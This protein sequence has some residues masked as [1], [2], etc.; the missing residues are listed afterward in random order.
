VVDFLFTNDDPIFVSPA[1]VARL[2]REC[3]ARGLINA[4]ILLEEGGPLS[5]NGVPQTTAESLLQA[6]ES[7]PPSDALSRLHNAIRREYV[8]D[9]PRL[10]TDELQQM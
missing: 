9:D 1:E 8:M 6:I 7:C 10:D 4:D 5:F 3:A 2:R